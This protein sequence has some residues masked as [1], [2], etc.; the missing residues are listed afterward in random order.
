MGAPNRCN[1]LTTTKPQPKLAEAVGEFFQWLPSAKRPAQLPGGGVA[2]WLLP[3]DLPTPLPSMQVELEVGSIGTVGTPLKVE[4]CLKNATFSEE[5][6]RVRILQEGD[7]G[8]T[9]ICWRVPVFE[10]G[11]GQFVYRLRV[12]SIR[13]QFYIL[14]VVFLQVDR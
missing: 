7:L 13:I 2:E 3:L 9:R 14:G 10:L 1:H 12:F 8:C 5:E 11:M 6:I 4:V